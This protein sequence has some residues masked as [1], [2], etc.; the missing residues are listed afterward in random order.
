MDRF[1]IGH[2]FE[3]RAGG[4]GDGGEAELCQWL[5]ADH[6]VLVTHEKQFRGCEADAVI[7]VSQAWAGGRDFARR[8]GVTRAVAHLAVITSNWHLKSER[9]RPGVYEC[10]RRRET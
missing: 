9:E 8:R 7:F 4:P 2:T 10:R 1:H 6:G 3:Y 5:D